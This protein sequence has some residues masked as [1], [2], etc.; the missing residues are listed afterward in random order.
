MYLAEDLI[1]FALLQVKNGTTEGDEPFERVPS[2]DELDKY[3]KGCNSTWPPPLDKKHKPFTGYDR[4]VSWCGIFATYCLIQVGARVRWVI[5][6]G[7]EDLSGGGDIVRVDG[8]QGIRRGDIAVRGSSSHHFIVLDPEFNSQ[9]GFKCVE[10]NSGGTAY[11]QMRY[12]YNLRNK[13]P[14]VR[15]YYRV[16]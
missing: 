13:L 15:L 10:G 6:Q 16:Y 14:D 11:P 9:K 4:T 3:F 1:D 8:N 7:I 12:G 5:S 2:K